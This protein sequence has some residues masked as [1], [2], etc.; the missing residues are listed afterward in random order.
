MPRAV[1]LVIDNIY[2][3]F[4]I[5][6]AAVSVERKSGRKSV[7]PKFNETRTPTNWNYSLLSL[8][9]LIFAQFFKKTT[10]K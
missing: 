1:F 6:L 3:K 9:C 2:R 7:H 5:E 10:E 4:R 8:R